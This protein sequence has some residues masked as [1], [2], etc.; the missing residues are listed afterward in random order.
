MTKRNSNIIEAA[1]FGVEIDDETMV[2]L[3]EAAASNSRG[4]QRRI[5]L[6]ALARDSD[7]L[8][9]ISI[10]APDVYKEMLE[11]SEIYLEHAKALVS[12]TE[13]AIYRLNAAKCT[14]LLN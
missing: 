13:K 12:I 6:L 5:V 1:A 7:N 9:N 10:Q 4:Q 14:E 2:Q 8:T 3:E 11:L